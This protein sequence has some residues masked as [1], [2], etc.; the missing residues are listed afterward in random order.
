MSFEERTVKDIIISGLSKAYGDKRVLD[1]YSERI[2]GGEWTVLMGPSGCGKTTLLRILMGL[3]KADQG[4]IE[5]VPG[6]I[7][8]V[9]QEDRLCERLSAVRNVALVLPH[10]KGEMARI[11]RELIFAGLGDSLDKPA[12][13]L[14]GGMR[15]RVSLVRACMAT[16]DALFLDEPLTGMDHERAMAMLAYIRERSA[17]KTVIYVTHSQEEAEMSGGRLV[18]LE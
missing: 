6:Q 3:E 18:R 16:S 9:F 12:A 2:R 4:R 1:D 10:P 17:G 8:A 11:R 5:G 13:S 14:S 15:R 7:A